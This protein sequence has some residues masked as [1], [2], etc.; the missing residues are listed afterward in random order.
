MTEHGHVARAEVATDVRAAGRRLSAGMWATLSLGLFVVVAAALYGFLAIY[1][2]GSSS[3]LLA[4]RFAL[5]DQDGHL[6]RLADYQGRPVLLLFYPGPDAESRRGLRSVRDVLHSF[7]E[8]GVKLFAVSRADA[9]SQK[10]FHDAEKLAFPL[11]ADPGGAVAREYRVGKA[12]GGRAAFVIGR[13]GKVMQSLRRLQTDRLGEQ[14]LTLARCCLD[15]KGQE[16][17]RAMGK[18]LPDFRLPP[19]QGGAPMSLYGGGWAR[20]TLLLFLSSECPCST[21]YGKRVVELARDYEPQGVRVLGIASGAGESPAAIARYAAAAGLRFPI[22]RDDGN[23]IADR[24]EARVTP[25]AY[26]LDSRSVLR[27]HGRID[28]N[29]TEGEV[30][31]HDLRNALDALLA[32]KLP[33]EPNKTAFGCAIAR[34]QNAGRGG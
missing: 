4:P 5:A 14:L 28:D 15:A 33:P 18:R 21:G 31:T 11:L 1:E 2:S 22:L 17:V 9:R 34:A 30:R 3:L 6:H 23:V 27:Y 25:E 19:V 7:D 16:T 13:D 12:A 26:L 8:Q 10:P 29:R 32:G 20:A 24:L